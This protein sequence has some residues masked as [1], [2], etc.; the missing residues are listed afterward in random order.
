MPSAVDALRPDSFSF[1]RYKEV[2]LSSLELEMED[3][4][5]L[6]FPDGEKLG[7]TS[8]GFRS[9]C[10]LLG[11]PYGFAKK[12]TTDGKSHVLGTLQKQLSRAMREPVVAVCDAEDTVL[13]FC[14]KH[15][16]PLRSDNFHML[17]DEIIKVCGTEN[18]KATLVARKVY[19]G[20]VFYYFD[21]GS[22]TI[23][24]D[25]E[26]TYRYQTVLHYCAV[27]LHRPYFYEQA[28]REVDGAVFVITE[29]P[30]YFES[31]TFQKLVND[32][33]A[34]IEGIKDGSFNFLNLTIAKLKA[35]TASLR[36]VKEARQKI[37]KALKAAE[38]EDAKEI[39]K[40]VEGIFRWR[41]I[42]KAY[43][44]AALDP[45][46]SKKWYMSA[47]APYDLFHVYSNFAREVTH[48]PNTL[49]MEAR[50]SLQRWS[51]K[52]LHRVPDLAEHAPPKVNFDL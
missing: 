10:A 27:G 9:L 4:L 2:E 3:E 24:A 52:M 23:D 33:L 36:E 32:L 35:S 41:K 50:L 26:S 38:N 21:Q 48:A 47:A 22:S 14:E 1:L 42:T 20:D 44:I 7:T 15:T 6:L 12:L 19:H 5:S 45:K 49:E 18:F 16:L 8:K 31:T 13:S 46:P 37:G 40:R 39:K 51:A 11:V 28:V 43:D 34:E 29:K 30:V 25:P 17:D